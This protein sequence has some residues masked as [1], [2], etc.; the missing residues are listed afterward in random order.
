MLHKHELAGRLHRVVSAPE[1]R[2]PAYLCFPTKLD[3]EPLS[4]AVE[5]IR[6]VAVAAAS[7]TA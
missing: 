4:L 2:L 7:E 6:R 5:T 3:S 1:F